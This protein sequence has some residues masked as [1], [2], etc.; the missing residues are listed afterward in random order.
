MTESKGGRI[1]LIERSIRSIQWSSSVV[2]CQLSVVSCQLPVVSCQL[3]VVECT[4]PETVAGSRAAFNRLFIAT[5]YEPRTANRERRTTHFFS[6]IRKQSGGSSAIGASIPRV[7]ARGL[8][9]QRPPKILSKNPPIRGVPCWE[10]SRSAIN[11]PRPASYSRT[12][13]N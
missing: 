5:N 6:V 11:R 3:S 1:D 9:D 7:L 4:V 13:R 2:S 10:S 8:V 12:D